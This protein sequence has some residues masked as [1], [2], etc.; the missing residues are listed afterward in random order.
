MKGKT[1]LLLISAVVVL[2]M[3]FGGT[4]PSWAADSSI[5][6]PA[7]SSDGGPVSAQVTGTVQ[8]APQQPEPAAPDITAVPVTEV[9]VT[10]KKEHLPIGQ[11]PD[12]EGQKDYVVTESSTGSKV[13][14]PSNEVPQTVVTVPA[15]VIQDQDLRT[16][17]D[18]M[19]NVAGVF[20]PY[21]PYYALDQ[22]TSLY[23]RGFQVSST[24][25]DGLWDPTPFGNYWM[26]DV[27]RIEVLKGPAGLLNGA[28]AGNIGGVINVISKQPLT[29]PTY[30][31]IGR[32]DSFGSLSTTA[33]I[34]QPL[35]K[36][37]TWLMRVSGEYGKY[38]SFSDQSSYET[39]PYSAMLQGLITS[40]DKIT[41]G[42]EHRWQDTHP[43]SGLPGYAVKGSGASSYLAR[44]GS[45]SDSLNVY[46]SRSDWTYESNTERL[47]Y[48]HKFSPDW[49]FYTRNQYTETSRDVTSIS[50]TPSFQSNGTVKYTESYSQIRMGPVFAYDTDNLV[51]GQFSVFGIKSNLIAGIRFAREFYN[52]DM[53]AP[54]TSFSK[55]S[56]TDPDNPAWDEPIIGLHRSMKGN[57]QVDQ[58]DYYANDVLS[59]TEKLKL[60]AGINFVDYSLQSQ[61]GMPGTN[62]SQTRYSDNGNGWRVG[63]LYDIFPWL[64]PFADYSTT[65]KPQGP[66]VTT[67]GT[68]QTFDPLSGDQY[69]FG[70]KADI[71]N[72]L[73]LT[74]AVYQLELKNV[75][76]S[77]PNP[78]LSQEGYEVETGE[79]RSR[80]F[81]L[82]A[83]YKVSPGWNLLLSYAHT[84][85]KIVQDQTYQSGSKVP[86]VPDDSLRL[87]SVYE[88]QS[89]ALAGLGF[90]GGMTA[91]SSRTT[92]LVAKATPNIVATLP[93]YATFDALT[94]YHWRNYKVS[95]NIKNLFD[96]QYWDTASSYGYL[97]PGSPFNATVRFQVSF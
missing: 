6:S 80:G 72:R 67:D 3:C 22:Q 65:F 27:D 56:F 4:G 24:L 12:A 66:N 20:S 21:P 40:D 34:S 41:L 38:E 90:G 37:K 48:Q 39:R 60:S 23:I 70:V 31:L 88:I 9:V 52:M 45:F 77:D 14:T 73:S 55:Y 10:A 58:L 64:T 28:Y 32:A 91:V 85:V 93:A 30:T 83:A 1:R 75:L 68:V 26:G 92:N 57:A 13:N 78:T 43:Y 79:Q 50:A 8:T 35:N 51:N 33:D 96:H 87:W 2:S 25:R 74:A 97:Y 76:E 63:L 69:E 86:S 89:G 15:K 17:T 81:E 11:Q 62:L 61:S 46:D 16:V 59:I 42:Y 36:D 94:Y 95:L 44:V 29:E 19:Q 7:A 82:D 53:Y 71:S 84:D 5:P 49:S 54:S 47:D 18:A